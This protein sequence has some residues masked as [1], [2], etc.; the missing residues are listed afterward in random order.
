[1][2][3]DPRHRHSRDSARKSLS[4][5]AL[6]MLSLACLQ[7]LQSAAASEGPFDGGVFSRSRP[8]EQELR[9]YRDSVQQHRQPVVAT[10]GEYLADADGTSN[11]LIVLLDADATNARTAL[12]IP[13][14][15]DLHPETALVQG[16]KRA[17]AALLAAL[18]APVDANYLITE[19]RLDDAERRLLKANDPRGRLQRYVVLRYASIG[20]AIQAQNALLKRL[21]P[22][23][24][25]NNRRL[26]TSWAPNDP[27]F[28]IKPNATNAA[29]YQWGLHLMN[30]P[31]AWDTER[32]H[33]YVAAIDTGIPATV[34]ADLAANYRTQFSDPTTP[35]PYGIGH[36]THVS[37]IIAATANNGA[38]VS[39]ACPSCSY[40]MMATTLTQANIAAKITKLVDQ[41]FQV[42]NMSF[43]RPTT[44][45]TVCPDPADT[46]VKPTCDALAYASAR[47]VMAVAAAGNYDA[48]VPQFPASVPS[49]LSV[50]GLQAAVAGNPIYWSKWYYGYSTDE[51]TTVGS[52]YPGS[53]GVMAP[54]RGIVSTLPAGSVWNDWDSYRCADTAGVDE[55]GP[56]GDG[57]ASCTGTSM[58]APFVTA[59]AGI[60][61]S[62]N[63]RLSVSQI[64][65]NIFNSALVTTQTYGGGTALT[66]RAFPRANLAV[67]TTVGQTSNRLTPLFAFYSD[68]RW[69][70]FYTTVPQMG[71]AAVLGT[72]APRASGPASGMDYNSAGSTITGYPYYPGT[73]YPS[74]CV[75]CASAQVWLFTTPLNPKNSAI[76][77]V[78]LYRLSWK[79]GDPSSTPPPASICVSRP[80]H[81]DT[82]YTADAAGVVAY[83]DS[84]YKLDGIEG[85]IYPKNVSPQPAGTVRLMRKYNPARDDHAIFPETLLGAM[86]AQGYTQDSGSDWLG[87]V[88]PNTGGV[89]VIQ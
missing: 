5:L 35:Y 11:E 50:G 20:A 75:K 30:F 64:R 71:A 6:A 36:G 77:L 7:S 54:A 66:S 73:S 67:S 61:R 41:G 62:I 16:V 82:V 9:A 72:L 45:K 10:V 38:G 40:A 57:Y 48:T 17:D 8:T 51:N 84:G 31:A 39:G 79:C 2:K 86:Q 19:N 53:G 63:P 89:P 24:V 1:M 29:Q 74:P 80:Y 4:G 49:V 88:Y 22:G 37:G 58:S 18:G 42:F 52:N 34:P 28:A 60:L 32:G 25:G 83:Q 3:T 56:A 81:I 68:K 15:A 27:Y 26:R 55:S 70:Y 87:Y 65:S 21:G 59:L 85:Y 23:S 47:D 76:P 46:D 14:R 13:A 69:D 78:P 43:G 33:G 12:P 44:P